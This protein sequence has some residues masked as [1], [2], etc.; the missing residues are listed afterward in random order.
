VSKFPFGYGGGRGKR[1]APN[2]HKKRKNCEPKGV[3]ILVWQYSLFPENQNTVSGI[4]FT[5]IKSEHVSISSKLLFFV[6]T[7][8]LLL[9]RDD[10]FLECFLSK[11]ERKMLRKWKTPFLALLNCATYFVCY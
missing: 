1:L 10:I 4:T 2:W 8:D 11:N 9:V 6:R 3:L 7:E 5:N